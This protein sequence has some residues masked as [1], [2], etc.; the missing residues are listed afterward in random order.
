M[1]GR[2]LPGPD[3]SGRQQLLCKGR[4]VEVEADEMARAE[5][6][7]HNAQHAEASGAQ[8]EVTGPPGAQA[9]EDKEIDTGEG[10]G[11]HNA[12]RQGGTD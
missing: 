9:Q 1:N 4:L 11:M 2:A 7:Q 8:W 12:Y 6:A 5:A 3:V 10:R